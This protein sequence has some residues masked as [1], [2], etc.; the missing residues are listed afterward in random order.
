MFISEINSEIEVSSSGYMA[1]SP[2]AQEAREKRAILE[3]PRLKSLI[4]DF[5]VLEIR[6][7]DGGYLVLTESMEFAVGVNYIRGEHCCGPANFELI[8]PATAEKTMAVGENR[9]AMRRMRA[10]ENQQPNIVKLGF[11]DFFEDFIRAERERAE[12]E[13]RDQESR[14]AEVS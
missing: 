6:K 5:P 7:I 13:R 12:A 11:R 9:S 10:Q 1:L 2:A 3:D 14:T 8:F 4:G